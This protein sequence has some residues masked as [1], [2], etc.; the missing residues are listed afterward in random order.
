[1]AVQHVWACAGTGV[2]ATDANAPVRALQF[3]E[4]AQFITAHSSQVTLVTCPC[5]PQVQLLTRVSLLLSHKRACIYYLK[6]S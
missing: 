1:M 6:G 5:G 2:V 4:L 3:L